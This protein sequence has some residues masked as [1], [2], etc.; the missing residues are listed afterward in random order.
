M[1]GLA[2]V[3]LPGPCAKS[4]TTRSATIGLPLHDALQG[5]TN[6]ERQP[7]PFAPEMGEGASAMEALAAGQRTAPLVKEDY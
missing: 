4:D 3:V 5:H 1:S 7:Y 6:R 2:Q